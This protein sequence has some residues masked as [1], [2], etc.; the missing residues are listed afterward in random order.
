MIR[1]LGDYI[2]TDILASLLEHFNDHI[3]NLRKEFNSKNICY[4]VQGEQL[5]IAFPKCV[6]LCSVDIDLVLDFF[7][8]EF[9]QNVLFFFRYL[10]IL[11][12]F[13]LYGVRLKE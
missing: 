8:L 9:I 11:L 2:G 7:D 10:M 1:D 3:K 5:F 12:Q 6:L 13:H 4:N